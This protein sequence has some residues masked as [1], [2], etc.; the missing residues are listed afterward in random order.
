MKIQASAVAMSGQRS[1]SLSVQ[2]SESLTI[3]SPPKDEK[4]VEKPSKTEAE[5]PTRL[6]TLKA[7]LLELL[8]EKLFGIQ[9]RRLDPSALSEEERAL[10]EKLETLQRQQPS[11]RNPEVQ[12]RYE[13]HE[14]TRETEDTRFAAQGLVRTADGKE[15]DFSVMLRM[16]REFVTEHH[17]R[18][19]NLTDPL[20]I[21][22]GG[23]AA[24]LTETKFRFDLDADGDE[25]QISFLK[26]G[27]GFLALDENGNGEIDDGRE[28]FG[29]QTGEGFGELA[30]FDED[31]NGWIDESDPIFNRLRIWTRDDKGQ[32]RLL[33]LGETGIG[34]LYLGHVATAF[35]HQNGAETLGRVRE[36]GV[37]LK[38]DGQAGTVQQIDLSL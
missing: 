31:G 18:A 34:A 11:R 27:S 2:R 3:V 7:E 17:V 38:E 26:P 20:V 25:D 16:S 22:F 35:S 5:A 13:L 29:P 12:F 9:L 32:S 14:T 24:E 37:F 30:R 8:L 36:T 33:A 19:G 28:L 4:K 15:I 6:D 23:N 10:F 1:Y 21:N